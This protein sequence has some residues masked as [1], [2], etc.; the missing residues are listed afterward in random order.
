MQ[1]QETNDGSVRRAFRVVGRV[2]GVGFRWWTQR[3][4]AELGLG[5]WVRNEADGSVVVHVMGPGG[6]VE[7]LRAALLKG[8]PGARVDACEEIATA[9]VLKADSFR[10]ER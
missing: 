7:R 9:G 2:Q 1:M 3:T 6:D 4:A 5:G 8:P 10:I